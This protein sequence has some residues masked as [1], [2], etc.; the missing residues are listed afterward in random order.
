M[1]KYLSAACLLL[2]SN[3]FALE[4]PE[5]FG[6][7]LVPELLAEKLVTDCEYLGEVASRSLWGGVV[8]GSL[9]QKG[10]MKRLY[11]KAH[12]LAA[13]HLV[14]VESSGT[15]YSGF[16]EGSAQA[17]RCTPSP[18]DIAATAS[19][20]VVEMSIEKPNNAAKVSADQLRAVNAEGKENCAFIKTITKGA[21]GGQ[22]PSQYAEIA[23]SSALTQ[24]ANDGADS[25][26]IVN[27]DTTNSGATVVVEALR[28][29]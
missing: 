3:T 8:A 25:Y 19:G 15:A 13:T 22:D 10:V 14:L 6:I 27:A 17:F 26:F 12:R 20:G 5:T 7:K 21:G 18:E 28:C 24:A 4:P 11:K 9:G 2:T 23:M 1:K 29:K 16:T